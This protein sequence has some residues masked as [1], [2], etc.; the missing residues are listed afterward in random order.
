MNLKS[1]TAGI[2]LIVGIVL[3]ALFNN[4]DPESDEFYH[5]DSSWITENP[6]IEVLG[7]KGTIDD[8]TIVFAA[9]FQTLPLEGNCQIATSLNNEPRTFYNPDYSYSSDY[10]YG[11]TYGLPDDDSSIKK[12]NI[13]CDVTEDT[14]GADWDECGNYF[15]ISVKYPLKSGAHADTVNSQIR[16]SVSNLV[17]NYLNHANERGGCYNSS[18]PDRSY[19]RLGDLTLDAFVPLANVGIFSVHLETMAHDPGAVT[20]LKRWKAQFEQDTLNFDLSTGKTFSLADMLYPGEESYRA[21]Q[22]AALAEANYLNSKGLRGIFPIPDGL[23]SV[24][25]EYRPELLEE[26]EFVLTETGIELDCNEYCFEPDGMSP[27]PRLLDRRPPLEIP[28]SRLENFWDPE[29]PF[30]HL[31]HKTDV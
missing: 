13:E 6:R 11:L 26:Q 31:K 7:Q 17:S 29:G 12:I 20:Q 14:K 25:D 10:I 18:L 4:S 19:L 21:F 1:A 5:L 16:E 28:F 15:E 30:R 24:I 9:I 22:R 2:V 3:V 23:P 27:V 8:E